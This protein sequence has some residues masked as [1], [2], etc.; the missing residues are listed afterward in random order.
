MRVE[1]KICPPGFYCSR[2]LKIPCPPG[3]YGD[4]HGLYNDSC[5]GPCP[6]G[7]FCPLGSFEP[8]VN[9]CP[10]GRYGSTTGLSMSACSGVCAK[11]YH[12]PEASTSPYEYE[13]SVMTSP[14]RTDSGI[15]TYPGDDTGYINPFL[16]NPVEIIDF[17]GPHIVPNVNMMKVQ[18]IEPNVVFCPEGTATPVTVLPGYY[19]TGQTKTTRYEQQECPAGAYCVKGVI[20]DCPAGRYGVGRRLQTANCTGPCAPGHYCPPGST[21]SQEMPCPIGRYGAEE[22]LGTSLCTGPCKKALDCPM[23]STRK[24]PS[25]TRIDPAVY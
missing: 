19:T 18:L 24:Q 14:N 16:D 17:S 3:K 6:K 9:R 10:A 5:S 12:C 13:C 20:Y 11:G 23:G 15:F 2:G 1:Q 21:R 8:R 22:G 4:E 25:L 7:H